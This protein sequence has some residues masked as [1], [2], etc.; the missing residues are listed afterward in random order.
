MAGSDLDDT[1]EATAP[2][3]SG[4]SDDRALANASDD[5][6][7]NAGN[8][9]VD[10]TAV[11]CDTPSKSPGTLIVTVKD[12]SGAAVADA[13]VS[14]TG[15]VQK[16]GKSQ[17]DGTTKFEGLSEG[18]YNATASKDGYVPPKAPATAKVPSG[19]TAKSP[20]VLQK[21][22]L[23]IEINNTSTA[24]DDIVQ[25]KCAVPAHRHKVSCQIR[26][27]KAMPADVNVVLTNPDG[28]L[29]F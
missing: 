4:D 16:Q 3:G 7:R 11:P 29:R 12:E 6:D 19:G 1:S 8:N 15:P 22:V 5:A 10:N 26:L 21:V 18:T 14:V 23:E 13:T 24:T 2:N 27:K 25:L 9:D 28:K 17:A 20:V